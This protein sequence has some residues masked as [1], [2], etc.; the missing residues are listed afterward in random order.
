M[1]GETKTK[2]VEI[3]M[4]NLEIAQ[5]R[6]DKLNRRAKKMGVQPIGVDVSEPFL[7]KVRVPGSDLNDDPWEAIEGVQTRVRYIE[8]PYVKL[9]VTGE[10]PKMTGYT[11]LAQLERIEDAGMVIKGL[12]G[13][14]IEEAWRSAESWCDHCASKRKRRTTYLFRDSAGKVIQIG[15]DCLKDFKGHDLSKLLD[16]TFETF[17]CFDDLE[18]WGGGGGGGNHLWTDEYLSWVVLAIRESGWL[19][20]KTA[21]EKGKT[22]TSELANELRLAFIW[23]KG[24]D[25][26]DPPTA[27]DSAKAEACI[28][29]V[30]EQVAP[31][32]QKSEYEHNL[33]LVLSRDIVNKKHL[34]I[35]ASAIPAWEREMGRQIER[36]KKFQDE[37]KSL[38]QGEVGKR[39][40][41]P[42]LTL[43]MGRV[44]DGEQYGPRTLLK[45]KDEAGN[46]FIWWASGG[47]VGWEDENGHERGG[48]FVQ[49][50]TYDLLAT[51]KK[52]DEYKGI[53]QTVIN[54][55]K[56]DGEWYCVCAVGTRQTKEDTHCPRGHEKGTWS[57]LSCHALNGP[58]QKE[59]LGQYKEDGITR[60]GCGHT[61]Q[62]WRCPKCANYNLKKAKTC[63]ALDFEQ[64]VCGTAKRAW[65]CRDYQCRKWNQDPKVNC[66]CGRD[67]KGNVVDQGVQNA[68]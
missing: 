57:C 44:F 16:F 40:V 34:G 4:D 35:A 21:E 67:V 20:K 60:Q 38:F 10:A 64:K 5:S 8:V 11:I 6:V 27:D 23:G 31:K 13:E 3:P 9:T 39:Q 58:S 30:R 65:M 48:D 22:R 32:L 45:F 66:V 1:D 14:E 43:V 61:L 51:V 42:G 56:L 2:S 26:P 47:R 52:H 63:I 18:G 46:I 62:S 15:S 59:C 17:T 24:K 7:K 68:Q 33:A 25:R 49:G 55:A 37:K 53:K 19:S 54:R 29:W 28:K 50:E 36:E 12:A 41:F